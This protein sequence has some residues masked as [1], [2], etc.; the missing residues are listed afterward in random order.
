MQPM[1][2]LK[3]H[4]ERR[5]RLCNVGTWCWWWTLEWPPMRLLRAE[6]MVGGSRMVESSPKM[7]SKLCVTLG[8]ML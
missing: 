3:E 2:T 8:A 7:S 5:K 4:R 6:E 1:F